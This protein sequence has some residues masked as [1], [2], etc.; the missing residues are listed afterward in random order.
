REEAGPLAHPVRPQQYI[1]INI[2][3]TATVYE[4]GAE[5]IRMLHS[6]VGP[7]LYRR[8]L[9]LYFE[10]HDGEA[11]TIEDWLKVFEDVS[12]RDLSQFRRWYE[13]AGTP[14]LRVREEWEDGRY[15]LTLAQETP[16]TPGQPEKLPLVIPV[17]YG[18]LA[19]DGRELASGLIEF[20][21]A[22]QSFTFDLPERPV[23]S[24]LRG[25]SAP[26]ILEREAA[27]GDHAVLLAYDSDPFNRWEAARDMA[28]ALLARMAEDETAEDPAFLAGMQAV[29]EDAAADPAF[30][31]L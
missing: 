22:E 28:L 19:R 18:L 12:G 24:L 5:V 15:T 21:E 8:A 7:E 10:R 29:A 4:K 30:A 31:A 25:F 17:A 3:Y 14:R 6:L 9:D 11:C 20:T 27:E 2:F 16:P 23:P 1:E 26:V 13:Q